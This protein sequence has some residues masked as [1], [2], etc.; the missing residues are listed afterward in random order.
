MVATF[1]DI[2]SCVAHV[3]SGRSCGAGMTCGTFY[4][5]FTVGAII[6][7]GTLG[8]FFI[9]IKIISVFT[10][11]TAFVG[12]RYGTIVTVGFGTSGAGT[13]G[14]ISIVGTVTIFS[15]YDAFVFAV[16]AELAVLPFIRTILSKAGYTHGKR[17]R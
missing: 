9:A 8:T 6:A 7:L 2:G 17:V 16:I 15:T 4:C 11:S 12:T 1:R 13:V 10:L 3:L 14:V 5:V